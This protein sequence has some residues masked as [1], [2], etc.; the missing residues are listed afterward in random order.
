MEFL[1]DDPTYVA[2]G[3]G[4]VAAALLIATKLTQQGKYLIGAG[5]AL[6]LALA[7]VGVERVWV[8]DNERVEATVYALGR[9]VAARDVPGV[10]ELLTPDVQ[11]VSRGNTTPSP[12]TRRMIEQ[13][14]RDSEFDFLH[15]SHLKASAGGQSRRGQAEFLVRCSG[16][17][18]T[19]YGTQNFAATNTTW[20]LGLRETSPGVWKVNRITP[21]S[22]PGRQSI[23]PAGLRFQVAPPPTQSQA[24]T[25]GRMS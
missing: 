21:V 8:T 9:A 6:A 24:L 4:L 18:H 13:L 11:Y 25:S 2:G 7:V 1:S 16:S 22:L 10:L 12:A 19:S 15:V 20:S 17:I 23:L 5:V 14:V 3:L